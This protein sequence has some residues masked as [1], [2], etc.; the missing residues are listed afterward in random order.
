MLTISLINHQEFPTREALEQD[1][2]SLG[3]ILKVK[4]KAQPQA[5]D[6]DL[7]IEITL[8]TDELGKNKSVVTKTA[9]S[10]YFTHTRSDTCQGF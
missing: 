9:R 7:G 10:L 4:K 2:S 1:C 3:Q 6:P 5:N 8:I